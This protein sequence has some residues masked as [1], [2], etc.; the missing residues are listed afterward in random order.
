[1]GEVVLKMGNLDINV[2]LG[3]IPRKKELKAVIPRPSTFVSFFLA[4]K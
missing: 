4:R 3:L 1:M 2:M